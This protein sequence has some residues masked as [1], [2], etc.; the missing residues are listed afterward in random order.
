MAPARA[1]HAGIH[2][3]LKLRKNHTAE[4]LSKMASVWISVAVMKQENRHVTDGEA[5]NSAHRRTIPYFLR[6]SRTL[7]SRMSARARKHTENTAMSSGTPIL[8]RTSSQKGT[9]HRPRYSCCN[10]SDCQIISE[11]WLKHALN[12]L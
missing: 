12:H 8:P 4:T 2:P 7:T 5:D 9:S 3:L 11:S 10:P 1:R 6:M